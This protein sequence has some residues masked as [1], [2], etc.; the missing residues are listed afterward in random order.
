MKVWMVTSR[1]PQTYWWLS[2]AIDPAPELL[3]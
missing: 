2:R 1:A 3:L